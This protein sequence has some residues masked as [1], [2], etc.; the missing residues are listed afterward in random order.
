[1]KLGRPQ[2]LQLSL[3]EGKRPVTKAERVQPRGCTLL[4]FSDLCRKNNVKHCKYTIISI[5]TKNRANHTISMS[6]L[7]LK[8][9]LKAICL[10]EGL[11]NKS[12]Q[13]IQMDDEEDVVAFLYA[14]NMGGKG[15]ECTLRE[16]REALRSKAVF[17]STRRQFEMEM[18][19]AEQVRIHCEEVAAT[20]VGG[21]DRQPHRVSDMVYMII[22][23][24]I[25]AHYVMY[26]MNIWELP[27]MVRAI[28]NKKREDVEMQRLLTYYTIMPHID[29]SKAKTIKDIVPLPWEIDKTAESAEEIEEDIMIAEAIEN[30]FHKKK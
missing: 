21:E 12:Y 6:K 5:G 27:S 16:M 13:E 28:E 9:N 20:P 17:Q 23:N 11:R 10:F 1:M 2:P 3:P 29:I 18:E 22:A 26:D 4:L 30:T 24:G 8:L 25:D 14:M 19:V 7:H 15:E